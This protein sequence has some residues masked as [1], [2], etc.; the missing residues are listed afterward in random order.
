MK[1]LFEPLLWFLL[2]PYFFVGGLNVRPWFG[3]SRQSANRTNA[4]LI[5]VL[6]LAWPLFL[7]FSATETVKNANSAALYIFGIIVL[8]PTWWLVSAWLKG[9]RERRYADSYEALSNRQRIAFGIS[10]P[11]LMMA[12][13]MII[14]PNVSANDGRITCDSRATQVTADECSMN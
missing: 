11:I 3:E 6:I 7:L 4:Q 5:V 8:M 1:R 10:T 14:A 13:V 12:S 2:V 9:E